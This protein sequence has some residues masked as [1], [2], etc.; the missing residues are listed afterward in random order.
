MPGV[1]F[2]VLETGLA[3]ALLTIEGI[4]NAP[5][6][7]L[8]EGIGR[9]V[10]TQTRRRIE[11]EKT[12]PQGEAWKPNI[13][14]T[15]ILYQSGELSRSIDYLAEPESIEVGSGLP[16]ARIHNEGGKIEPKSADAL[17]FSIGNQFFLV[18][19]VTMP[20][21]QYLG[22]SGDNELEIV[23]TAEDWLKGLA[24]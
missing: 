4:E 14:G 1:A 6:L 3:E 9:L 10:Q 18:K 7:E 20:Q 22:I 12:S 11:E 23:E 17:A 21:R 5:T 24:A 16:Y 19:S 15:S 8:A 2:E 13:T